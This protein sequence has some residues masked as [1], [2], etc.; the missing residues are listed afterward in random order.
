MDGISV[1]RTSR[2]FDI[3]YWESVWE[4]VQLPQEYR[5][6]SQREIHRYLTGVL[7]S[8]HSTLV[9]IG[10]APG[11]WL[12]YFHRQ[13]GLEV[14]GIDHAP[15]ACEKTV[16]NLNQLRIPAEIHNCDLFGFDGVDYDIV[17]S[18][19]FIEHFQEPERAI[20]RIVGICKSGGLVITIVP[21]LEGLN[22]WI[23][24]TFRPK[25]AEGHFPIT[26]NRLVPLHEALGVRTLECKIIRSL[27]LLPPVDKNWFAEAWPRT[28][29]SINLPFRI[30]NKL[31]G[32]ATRA[33][34]YYPQLHKL[35]GGTIYIGEKT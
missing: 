2:E 33:L 29:S 25:V 34:N 11:R 32:E 35:C 12:A 1:N 19:G 21:A 17:F 14:S 9:E 20:E 6:E 15:K 10:C 7:P 18:S 27:H 24:R 30:W 8:R 5:R 4:K 16:E 22:W 28:S 31:V 3:E 13:F 26:K 23:S